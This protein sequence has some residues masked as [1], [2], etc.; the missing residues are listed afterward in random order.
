MRT[1]E[2]RHT[3][4]G[5]QTAGDQ[6][7]LSVATL[8]SLITQI[9]LAACALVMGFWA[10]LSWIGLLG[11]GICA[12]GSILRLIGITNRNSSFKTSLFLTIAGG[13]AVVSSQL[14]PLGQPRTLD[15][16]HA[17]IAWLIAAVVS[18][19]ALLERDRDNTKPWKQIALVWGFLGS[20]IWLAASYDE[21][22]P[23]SFHVGLALNIVLLVVSKSWFRMHF[24]LV[25]IVNTM[26]LLLALLPVADLALRLSH[27]MDM[28]PET[29]K[30]Y[31]SYNVA[32]RKPSAFATW[33]KYYNQQ[34]EFMVRSNFMRD[35]SGQFPFR[36]RPNSRGHLF[37]STICINNKGFRGKDISDEKGDVFRIVAL[38]ESTTF[39]CTLNADD[40]PWPEVLEELVRTRLSLS[41]PVEVINAGVPGYSLAHN[42]QR[43]QSDILPLKPGM[44]I[45]YHGHNGFYLLSTAIEHRDPPLPPYRARPLKLL[46]DAEHGLK[47]TAY[48][49]RMTAAFEKDPPITAPMQSPYAA[50]YR[51]L[52][53]VARTNGITLVVG[54]FSM[55]A[56]SQSEPGVVD[57]YR[58]GY[59]LAAARVRANAIHSAMVSQLVKENPDIHFVDTHPNLDGDHEKF[60]DLVHFTQEGRQQLAET[61]FTGITNILIER[62]GSTETKHISNRPE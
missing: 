49:R 60:I 33:W 8:S 14:L 31:Y 1:D 2:A 10:T 5:T 15:T 9:F 11:I 46:A 3:S 28:R 17:T 41:R 57:F 61:F 44:I 53:D 32:R 56:N 47:I 36:L 13:L 7:R 39:G 4:E 12:G 27:R 22:L 34:W 45:S 21:N 62:L 23:V 51:E 59:P 30:K 16:Y 58:A 24:I 35:A 19:P 48:K 40:K 29:G 38:G 54:N 55:A 50:A 25:Q 42:L 6:K 26:I 18:A 37:H 52:I 43:L 20:I